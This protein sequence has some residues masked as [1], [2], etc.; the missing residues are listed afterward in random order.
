VKRVLALC[1]VAG[2]AVALTGCGG[3][4]S[5]G[6]SAAPT[7]S[8]ASFAAPTTG[9]GAQQVPAGYTLDRAHTGALTAHTY[10]AS[11]DVQAALEFDQ[12]EGGSRRVYLH[13]VSGD[14]SAVDGVL[15]CVS[16]TFPSADEASRFFGSYRTLRHQAGP[17]VRR[18]PAPDVPGL[19][20]TTSYLEREQSFRGYGVSSTNVVE[21]AGLAGAVLD[22]AS[23]AA[24]TPSRTLGTR[25]I[26]SMAGAS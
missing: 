18:L 5:P 20:G 16:L 12:L 14:H 25:L 4:S 10:S 23:V 2:A 26:T 1:A 24:A 15:S 7:L 17:L 21:T 13:H 22:I 3:G 8:P 9:C 11:A 19:T 6:P